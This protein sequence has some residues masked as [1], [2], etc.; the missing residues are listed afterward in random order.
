MRINPGFGKQNIERQGFW[1]ALGDGVY[2]LRLILSAPGP[3]PDCA[4]RGGVDANDNDLA[5]GLVRLADP[6]P[7]VDDGCV[8]L[9]ERLTERSVLL[10]EKKQRRRQPGASQSPE[11]ANLKALA[12]Q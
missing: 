7:K 9:I 11:N 5:A 10:C 6:L 2:K 3:A 8:D 4:D 1:P 12:T